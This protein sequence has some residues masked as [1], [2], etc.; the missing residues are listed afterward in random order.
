MKWTDVPKKKKVGKLSHDF[1]IGRCEIATLENQPWM[2]MHTHDFDELVFVLGGSAVHTIDDEEYPII[3]GDVFVVRG[4]HKHG[5]SNEKNFHIANVLYQR[6]FFESLKH[7]LADLPG[8]NV[9]FVHEPFYRKKHKFKSKLHL[10]AR[11]LRKM[12]ELLNYMTTEQEDI[13]AGTAALNEHIFSIIVINLCKFF[14]EVK[15]PQPKTLLRI[16]AAIDFIEHN[17][18]KPI[19]NEQLANLADMTIGSFRYL[20]KKITGLSPI[21]YLIRLR[22]EKAADIMAKNSGMRVIDVAFK[23]GFENSAYFTKKFKKIIGITPIAYLK[24][25]RSLV[26]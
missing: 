22:I 20:F 17:F 8:F 9:L 21:D 25:Q 11:Q 18:D 19:S 6:E 13:W 4:N 12:S 23:V 24:N 15:S 14:Q 16:S 2:P 7:A 3:R 10:N 5:Y 26:G 1:P